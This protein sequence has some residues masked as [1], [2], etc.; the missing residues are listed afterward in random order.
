LNFNVLE[1]L[2]KANSPSGFENEVREIIIE[3]IKGCTDN[4]KIDN[5]GNLLVFKR[6]KATPN[7]KLL[8]SAHMDEVGFIVTDIT[9]SG[10]LTFSPVG[11]I[12]PSAVYG[13]SVVVGKNRIKGVITTKPVHLLSAKESN[14]FCEFDE[15]YIDIGAKDKDQAEKY[16]SFGDFVVFDSFFVADESIIKSKALD[17][18]IGCAILI[19]MIKE[20]LPFDIYFSF[21]V[22]EEVGLRGAKVAAYQIKP[23]ACVVV[24]AT[25][26]CDI[27]NV[28]EEKVVCQL[29][30]G[31]VVAFA[32]KGTIYDRKYVN[33]AL[34]IAKF[35]NLKVQLKKMVV[36]GN[37]SAAI[38]VSGF[39]V[40]TIA[41][42]LPCRYLHTAFSAIS[43]K[44][45]ENTERLLRL[46]CRE[47]A[48]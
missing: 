38:N 46:L 5:I 34:Q 29:N 10:F 47:I 7:V 1:K 17:D 45:V 8:L 43:V 24:E 28:S 6:G 4:V 19:D 23:D 11:G 35:N 41:L 16:V 44:D 9:K 13:N 3:E 14:A 15:L 37:D 36:G 12:F 18:R 22:Q 2:C 27:L 42:S 48:F 31:A 30:K 32:D 21:V 40:R 33:S 20:N 25:T 39:G 26:A